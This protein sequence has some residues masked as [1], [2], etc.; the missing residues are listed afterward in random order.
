MKTTMKKNIFFYCGLFVALFNIQLICSQNSQSNL[1]KAGAS[2][3]KGSSPTKDKTHKKNYV[4]GEVLVRF[5]P[6]TNVP[7]SVNDNALRSADE[8]DQVQQVFRQLKVTNIKPIYTT[9]TKAESRNISVVKPNTFKLSFDSSST[10]TLKAIEYLKKMDDVLIAE[11]NYIKK[12]LGTPISKISDPLFSQQWAIFATRANELW[13]VPTITNKRPVIAILD[14]GLDIDHEEFSGKIWTNDAELNGL[15]GVDDDGNGYVDDSIGYSMIW[16]NSR[17]YDKFGHGTHCAGIAAAKSNNKGL[18]GMN[19]DAIIMPVQ[20]LGDDGYGDNEGIIEGLNYAVANGADVISLSLGSSEYSKLEHEA[21]EEASKHAIIVAAAGND[22]S[23]LNDPLGINFPGSFPSVLGVESSD[24]TCN[25][26]DFSNWDEDGPIY[27]DI[28]YNNQ[29]FNYELR[30]PGSGIIST[31]PSGYGVMSGTSMATPCVAGII[32]RLLQCKVYN[33]RQTLKYDLINAC[34]SGCI[35]AM[36]AYEGYDK[37]NLSVSLMT[38]KYTD[39]NG[40][41]LK[42]KFKFGATV[43]AYPVIVNLG[44]KVNDIEIRFSNVEGA[45]I[46]KESLTIDHIDAGDTVKVGPVIFEMPEQS[47]ENYYSNDTITFDISTIFKNESKSLH[48]SLF[49][50]DYNDNRR[51]SIIKD[52]HTTVI[53]GSIALEKSLFIPQG[54]TLIIKPNTSLTLKESVELVCEGKLICKADEDSYIHF[55]CE[56]CDGFTFK[57]TIERVDFQFLEFR[58]NGF[59]GGH[60]KECKI[61]HNSMYP[62][63]ANHG[64]FAQ[65]C[66]F[67]FCKISC[68]AKHLFSNCQFANSTLTN[69]VQKDSSRSALQYLPNLNNI[70]SC[71]IYDNMLL[72]R[73]FSVAYYSDTFAIQA[74]NHPSYLGSDNDSIVRQSIID[75]KH[76]TSP[77]GKGIVDISNK[78]NQY[79]STAPPALNH[80][81][82]NGTKLKDKTN[83]C[84]ILFPSISTIKLVFSSP[85]DKDSFY[86]KN[87]FNIK[88]ESDTVI[89]ADIF[90]GDGYIY[91]EFFDKTTFYKVSFDLYRLKTDDIQ[92][93][94][95]KAECLDGDEIRLSWDLIKETGNYSSINVYGVNFA[96]MNPD[97]EPFIYTLL[98]K[99]PLDKT[100][101]ILNTKHD[102]YG[103]CL[104]LVNDNEEEKDIYNIAF[105]Y[106]KYET[107]IEEN[108]CKAPE[109][110]LATALE[111]IN[112]MNEVFPLEKYDL[113]CYDFISDDTINIQDFVKVYNT[114]QDQIESDISKNNAVYTIENDIL[115][116]NASSPITAVEAYFSAKGKTDFEALSGLDNMEHF[117]QKK[118]N[119]DYLLLAYSFDG[120]KIPTGKQPLLKL[121]KGAQLKSILLSDQN[122]NAFTLSDDEG[123]EPA[124]EG[125]ATM[126]YF[127][128]VG[129]EVSISAIKSYPGVYIQVKEHDGKVK[130]AIKFRTKK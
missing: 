8:S 127:N 52:N 29:T 32:S 57:D 33:D 81:Y 128:L 107:L 119:G 27:S 72:D 82:L 101:I 122:G 44:E 73:S 6:N 70:T 48:K 104:R 59:K 4:E 108:T 67:D 84:E 60:L 78:L 38:I 114:Y 120:N 87:A 63:I 118:G 12:A 19:P 11:P 34:K 35:D 24:S 14:T 130:D 125:P 31:M 45:S 93:D 77:I 62:C 39:E 121:N 103:Y 23:S 13:E 17:I 10:S 54:D 91:G 42:N 116:V 98:D 2:I 115:Y 124:N 15:P 76:P 47:S 109:I 68:Q 37:N 110:G 123:E 92:N 85:M 41:E 106:C 26:S 50:S 5:K 51:D 105:I 90:I 89:T 71:N 99:I 74:T 86:I 88:W 55:Q 58:K 56:N 94:T 30:A 129:S 18:I 25:L 43:Y 36:K 3:N 102:Y 126:H 97:K 112:H 22:A 46:N 7:T 16:D 83:N 69:L 21:F 40:T 95:F 75:A 80:I 100:D 20:V 113:N 96:Y 53:K 111:I 28:I 1:A 66:S 64:I 79:S 65:D 61:I 49:V 117:I 9:S